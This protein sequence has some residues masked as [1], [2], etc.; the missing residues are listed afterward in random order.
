MGRNPLLA[1]FDLLTLR[2]FAAVCEEGSINRAAAREHIALSALSRR[3]S[4]LEAVLGLTLLRRHSRGVEPT[5][6][7]LAMLQHANI[8]LRDVRQMEAD[9]AQRMDGVRGTIRLYANTWAIAEY[10]PAHISAFLAAHPLLNVEIEEAVSVETLRAVRD[11]TADIGI[12]I[13]EMGGEGL[14]LLPYAGDHLVAI[15]P[16]GHPLA[17]SCPVGLAEIAP[18]DVI[19]SSKGSALEQLVLTGAAELGV[20]LRIRA[21]ISGFE[22][23]YRM[24]QAGLGIGIGP[25]RPARRHCA[26]MNLV[27]RPL[28]EAWS[29]R[30]LSI[31]LSVGQPPP[32]VKLL[33]DHLVT[34]GAAFAA[35]E[36]DLP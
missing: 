18:Y 11:G 15:M 2:L 34:A 12:V 21:R 17:G 8:I 5:S 25:S 16:P 7:G 26:A 4:D 20:A 32:H 27:M 9:L 31:C 35:G 14:H 3:I 36:S 1:G 23:L 6:A 19:G 33:V 10:V 24:I 28:N 13:S 29:H 30:R 22:T